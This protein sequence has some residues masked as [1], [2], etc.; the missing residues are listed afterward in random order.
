MGEPEAALG[1]TE[2]IRTLVPQR[3]EKVAD[4]KEV[5]ELM[6]T[7]LVYKFTHLSREEIETMFGL[8]D[9]RETRVYQEGKAEG[10][11]EGK[12]EGK[13]EGKI[14]AI[15]GLIAIGLTIEQIATALNLEVDVVRQNIG[16]KE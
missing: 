15:P 2:Q 5:I 7:V 11:A 6:Q 14:E 1:H 4:Q 16:K 10:K 8:S 13:A 12:V 3:L 9:L